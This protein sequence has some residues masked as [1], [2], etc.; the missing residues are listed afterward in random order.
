MLGLLLSTY[1]LYSIAILF[2]VEDAIPELAVF[3]RH[4]NGLTRILFNT[5]LTPHLI[6]EG[7]IA[8]ADQEELNAKPTSSGKA[9][10]VLPKISSALAAGETGSFY[11]MLDI[12]KCHGNH[13]AQQLS[14]TI[15]NELPEP[16]RGR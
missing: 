2:T 10:F 14:T 15:T 16:R 7:V 8:L 13:D 11:K 3:Q 9:S 4:F 1:S 12:M 6:A 5:N